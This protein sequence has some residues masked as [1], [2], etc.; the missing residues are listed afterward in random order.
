MS[1]MSIV[2]GAALGILFYVAFAG[3]LRKFWV[4]PPAEPNPDDIKPV[5]LKYRCGV[6]GSEV[7]MTMAPEGDIPAAPRHCREDMMQTTSD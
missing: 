2:I 7:T 3:A 5:D 1:F 6:C 4:A